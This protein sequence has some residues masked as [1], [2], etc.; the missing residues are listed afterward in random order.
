MGRTGGFTGSC[1][2]HVI[3]RICGQ[4]STQIERAHVSALGDRLRGLCVAPSPRPPSEIQDHRISNLRSGCTQQHI[5]RG[6]EHCPSLIATDHRKL[7]EKSVHGLV[8]LQK[9]KEELD[10]YCC[11]YK[12]CTVASRV[13]F[14][15]VFKLHYSREPPASPQKRFRSA[16]CF[17]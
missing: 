11:P 9:L 17:R 4:T 5:S 1:I 7:I 2:A 16:A 13:A 3:C 15:H 10:R 8:V 6:A 12:D 14:D